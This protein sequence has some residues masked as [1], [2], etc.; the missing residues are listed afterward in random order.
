MTEK[1][2]HAIVPAGVCSTSCRSPLFY[3]LV[4]CI[5]LVVPAISHAQ[6]YETTNSH[7]E[8]D[9]SVPLHSFTGRTDNLTGQINLSEGI[10]D[11]YVD[12]ATVKT[13]IDARDRDMQETIE[14]DRFPFAEFYGTLVTP[15]DSSTTEPQPVAVEGDFAVHGVS[16]A[17]RIT[18]VLQREGSDLRVTAEWELNI[19]DYDIVPPGI[20]F[21]RVSEIQKVRINALLT[22]AM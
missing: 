22:P 18:G 5:I 12:L 10:V 6:V 13:G 2:D 11:F 19:E 21:Y 15:F 14:T 3:F 16:R 9:S 8:F 7:V 20:L 4:I 1:P 17:V